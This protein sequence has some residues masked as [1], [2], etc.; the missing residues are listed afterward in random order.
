[1]TAST[2]LVLN[3]ACT[4]SSRAA[5]EPHGQAEQEHRTRQ[6]HP[7]AE[8]QRAQVFLGEGDA[9]RPSPF[10][11]GSRSAPRVRSASRSRRSPDGSSRAQVASSNDGCRKSLS[12]LTIKSSAGLVPF[13]IGVGVDAH[14]ERRSSGPAMSEAPRGGSLPSVITCAMSV[15]P[16]ACRSCAAAP[17][18]CR[19]ARSRTGCAP[20]PSPRARDPSARAS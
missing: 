2:T 15:A 9:C 20:A 16:N 10:S 18:S 3:L 5:V 1:M 4:A 14:G 7:D 6:Q 12:P 11:A 8:Q 17:R 19:C 13:R